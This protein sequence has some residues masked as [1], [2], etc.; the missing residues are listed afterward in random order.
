MVLIS[1]FIILLGIK[2]IG[3]SAYLIVPIYEY[4]NIWYNYIVYKYIQ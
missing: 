2:I 1:D 3:N 4:M